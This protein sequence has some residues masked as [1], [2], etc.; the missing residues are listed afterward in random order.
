MAKQNLFVFNTKILFFSVI[1]VFF[2]SNRGGIKIP[3]LGV[4]PVQG[5]SQALYWLY[6]LPYKI[7]KG[8]GYQE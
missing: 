4:V 5:A 2:F 1:F 8:R 7:H 3:I 6:Q